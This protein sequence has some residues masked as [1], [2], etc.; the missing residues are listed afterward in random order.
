LADKT[1]LPHGPSSAISQNKFDIVYHG[2][3]KN[4]GLPLQEARK[5]IKHGHLN[6]ERIIEI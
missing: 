2:K 6:Q 5:E 3:R 4:G 1:A